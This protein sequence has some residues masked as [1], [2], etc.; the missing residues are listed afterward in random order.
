MINL[1]LSSLIK[2]SA[3]LGKIRTFRSDPKLL[4]GSVCC[5][6]WAPRW[7]SR[8]EEWALLSVL[9]VVPCLQRPRSASMSWAAL[10]TSLPGGA[11]LRDRPRSCPGSPRPSAPASSSSPR[12]TATTRQGEAVLSFCSRVCGN[13]LSNQVSLTVPVSYQCHSYRVI[14]CRYGLED[15]WGQPYN[16]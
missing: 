9:C 16:A 3:F 4:N 12:R 14:L 6:A 11:L 2:N 1:M 7:R 13:H 8:I 5:T 10:L 15:Q